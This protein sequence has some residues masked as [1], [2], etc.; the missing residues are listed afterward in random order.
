MIR[1]LN[2]GADAAITLDT[3]AA[4][5]N[6]SRREAEQ[7]VHDARMVG[8]PIISGSRGLWLATT[9]Q[10]AREAARRFRDRA[11]HQMA[12]AQALERAAERMSDPLTLWA[13]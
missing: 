4:R 10:E 9:A 11:V 3:L 8:V 1:H 5:M 7:A 6:V 13:A 2:V 12:T